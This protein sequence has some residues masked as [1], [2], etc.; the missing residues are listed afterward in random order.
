M[1][2]FLARAVA[3]CC[4]VLALSAVAPAVA[5]AA[6]YSV[7]SCRD[8]SGV[9]ASA[10]AWS[11]GP[12]QSGTTDTCAGGGSLRAALLRG[13]GPAGL[14]RGFRFLLP[15]GATISAYRLELAAQTA[16]SN[17][18]ATYQAGVAA[19]APLTVAAIDAGCPAS[20]CTFGNPAAPLDPGNLLI[21]DT[22]S[23]GL[24]VGVRCGSVLGCAPA[25]EDTTRAEVRLFRSRV[26][27]RDDALPSIAPGTV[28]TDAT[29]GLATVAADVSDAGG[30]VAAVALQIDGVE[31]VRTATRTC[32]E[33]YTGPAPCPGLVNAGFSID[34]AALAAGVHDVRVR[35]IDA[36]GNV[37][38]GPSMSLTA[39][40]R[41][42]TAV[43]VAGPAPLTPAPV[44]ITVA[45]SRID[46]GASA[47]AVTG[48][49]RTPAGAPVA[50]ARVV[51]RS[52]ALGVYRSA[53]RDEPALTTDA[54]GRF[55]MPVAAPSRVLR[56]G[57]DDT[58]FRAG[59]PVEVDLLQSLR[60]V[61]RVSDRALKNGDTMTLRA[62]I[63]G[64]GGGARGKVALVQTIVGGRW[65][66]VASLQADRAGRAVWRYRFRG[67]TRPARY[68][69]RVRVER[70]GDAW[71]WP[72]THS[73]AVTVAVAP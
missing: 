35:G 68:R 48:F 21:R 16:A 38:T 53:L 25:E 63:A 41:P 61:V 44:V 30:G 31:V 12:D 60:I 7:W 67:T 18:P 66:T 27:I 56:L 59:D 58:A 17:D 23:G 34:A 70:A 22:D 3:A 10:A 2:P 65:S 32:R 57:V 9:P 15:A 49:V 5:P 24:V 45:R 51:V 8:Q 47:P 50:G 43:I 55:S 69:F 52:R 20:G 1:R 13:D 14:V 64:A 26:D 37:I 28:T 46:L 73:P 54:A 29:S 71:P 33:P 72:T 62:A 40:P 6:S 42:S 36:A 4:A 39:V 19:D 11:A